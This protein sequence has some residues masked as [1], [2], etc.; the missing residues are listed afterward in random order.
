[1]ELSSSGVSVLWIAT[2]SYFIFVFLLLHFF[3][4]YCFGILN[5]GIWSAAQFKISPFYPIILTFK[6]IK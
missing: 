5:K 1:M 6:F 4:I 2:F 3:D